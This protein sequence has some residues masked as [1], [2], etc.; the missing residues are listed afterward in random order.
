MNISQI[1]PVD[2]AEVL[3]KDVLPDDGLT[4]LWSDPPKAGESIEVAPGIHW[5][6]MPLP[7]ALDH[8]NLWLLE[9]DDGW[10]LVDTGFDSK[11]TQGHWATLFETVFA[12]RRPT[13][14]ICTHHHPDHMG[15]AGWLTK[16]YDIPLWTTPK[17][18]DAFHRWSR[19]DQESLI[20]IMREFY[21]RGGVSEE[22]KERDLERRKSIGSRNRNEPNGFDTLSGDDVIKVGGSNWDV[23]IGEGHAPELAALF[24]EDQKILISSDQVLPKISPNVSVMPFDLDANPLHAFIESLKR[25]RMLPEDALVLPSH[26]L[27]FRGLHTRIDDLIA[28]HNDRL[29]ETVEACQTDATAA[30]VT[31]VL[32]PRALN[33]H[34]YFFALGETLAHLNFLW[35]K[36]DLKRTENE[37]GALVYSQA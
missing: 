14:L 4:Y 11:E 2:K 9:D 22:R 7:F 8:I 6:R 30:D 5:I 31:K 18:W 36:Q 25:F 20:S 3:N 29:A 17:E 24:N 32:F 35:L 34:Q 33:D 16:T 27:P 15:L 13:K 21:R 19:L 1:L 26:K 23:K 28:H 37:S 10:V 12:R